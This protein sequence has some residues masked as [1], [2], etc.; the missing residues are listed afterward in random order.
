MLAPHSRRPASA[1]KPSGEWSRENM[2]FI[3]KFVKIV[4]NG[5]FLLRAT[6]EWL[7]EK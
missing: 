6:L 7:P 2:A 5:W 4:V 1:V 3:R